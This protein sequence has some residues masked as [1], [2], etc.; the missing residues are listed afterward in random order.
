MSKANVKLITRS[1][2]Q[3][4]R[5]WLKAFA[6][7]NICEQHRRMRQSVPTK[8]TTPQQAKEQAA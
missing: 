6:E 1:T 4:A 8:H 7:E 3:L 5:F 2:F